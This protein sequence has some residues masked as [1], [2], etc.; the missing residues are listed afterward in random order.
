MKKI[1]AVLFVVLA[2]ACDSDDNDTVDNGLHNPYTGD[3]IG[4]WKTVA[5]YHNGDQLPIDCESETP[6]E[7][8]VL[9]T[10]YEDNTFTLEHNCQVVLPYDGGTYA[11]TGNVLT[12]IMG[13]GEIEEKAHM[14]EHVADDPATDTPELILEWRFGIGSGGMFED[15]DLQVQKMPDPID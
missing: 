7:Q 2:F 6:T 5:V 11:K 3:V 15:Y 8:D 9:F 1:F 12:L 10:F 4:T 14:V 13:D